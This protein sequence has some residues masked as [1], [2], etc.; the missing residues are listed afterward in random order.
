MKESEIGRSC[1]TQ[2][3]KIAYKILVGNMKGRDQSEA[4][5]WMGGWYWVGS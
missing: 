4:E 3:M 2:Q 1:S 5:A